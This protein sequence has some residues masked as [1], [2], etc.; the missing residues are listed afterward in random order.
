MNREFLEAIQLRMAELLKCHV[1]SRSPDT[2]YSYDEIIGF[3]DDLKGI[4]IK[5]Y[6][7]EN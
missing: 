4:M 1:E 3:M 6:E 2:M 7:K 5:F